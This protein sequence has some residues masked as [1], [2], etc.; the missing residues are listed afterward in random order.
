MDT[1]SD[2]GY[3]GVCENV[4]MEQA[5]RKEAAHTIDVCALLSV[6]RGEFLGW[7]DTP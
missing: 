3:V 7:D 6:S 1:I 5:P 4:P 2:Y